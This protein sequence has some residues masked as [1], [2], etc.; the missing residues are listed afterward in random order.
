[1]ATRRVYVFGDLDAGALDPFLDP[2]GVEAIPGIGSIGSI[3]SIGSIGGDERVLV[4]AWQRLWREQV[5]LEL[6]EACKAA[7]VSLLPVW[8]HAELGVVGPWTEPAIPGCSVCAESRR[9][10]VASIPLA[11]V[12]TLAETPARQPWEDLLLLIA[13]ELIERWRE[14][15]AP[16]PGRLY[17]LN[18]ADLSGAWHRFAPSIDCPSCGERRDDPGARSGLTLA[19]CPQEQPETFRAR[20]LSIPREDIRR[21][22]LDWRYGVTAHVFR[23]RNAPQALTGV[24]MPTGRDDARESGWGR[25]GTFSQSEKVAFLEAL[26]RHAALRPRTKQEIESGSYRALHEDAIDPAQ[27]G[28]SDYDSTKHPESRAV[29]YSDELVLPWVWGY[30]FAKKRPVLVPYQAVYFGV[31]G[32]KN[33]PQ[34]F[35]ESSNGCA[36][37]SCLEEAI[38]HGLFEVIERDS[39]LLTWYARLPVPELELGGV[40]NRELAF[41]EDR[42]AAQGYELSVFD[43]TL[44]LEVPAVWALAVSRRDDRPVSFTAAGAHPDPVQ[45]VIGA[46]RELAGSVHLH[47]ADA[48]PRDELRSMLAEPAKIKR[49]ADHVALYTLPEAFERFS[50][51]SSGPRRPLSEAHADWRAR[52]VRSDLTE[53]LRIFVDVILR[54]GLD[55]VVIDQT[56]PE[57]RSIGMRSVKVLIPGALPM[58]FGHLNRRTRGLRRLLEVPRELGYWKSPKS[59]DELELYPHPFP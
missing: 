3:R 43:T 36:S 41:L 48:I 46:L 15:S 6:R 53:T 33:Q 21:A 14:G 17:T 55:V 26:E 23:V 28:L 31:G 7:N 18:G 58:T 49:M 45:A 59:Y 5:Q 8:T 2:T 54:R 22:L 40:E 11:R 25:G 39:F 4:V 1:M 47:D 42:I 29:P 12:R 52:W 50:F 38:L 24:E 9:R 37:G 27:L 32:L 57:Q 10:L 51:S 19:P 20:P 44:D 30:S 34:I 56:S 35:Y 13:A 16:Q